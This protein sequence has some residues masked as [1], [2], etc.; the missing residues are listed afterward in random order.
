MWNV[1]LFLTFYLDIG[2]KLNQICCK[3]M[4]RMDNKKKP[5]FTLSRHPDTSKNVTNCGISGFVATPSSSSSW[6]Y[7]LPYDT[8]ILKNRPKPSY[9]GFFLVL[10][11][12]HEQDEPHIGMYNIHLSL[13]AITFFHH[14]CFF[15]P[16]P[17]TLW[18]PKQMLVTLQM[19]SFSLPPSV[20]PFR[21]V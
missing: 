15:L 3:I 12:V 20:Y 6:P 4:K 21:D 5:Q 1:C 16:C 10:N 17:Y 14:I 9:I 19:S 8:H 7:I 13:P 18:I 11:Y 2:S